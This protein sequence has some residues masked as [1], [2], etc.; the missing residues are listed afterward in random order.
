VGGGAVGIEYAGEVR[1]FYPDK[2]ATIV[3][4]EPLLLSKYFPDKF[5]KRMQEDVRAADADIILNDYLEDLDGEE[6]T[7][8]TTRAGKT[9]EA[10]LVVKAFGGKPATQF[11]KSLGDDVL[12]PNGRIRVTKTLQLIAHPTIFAAGDATDWDESKQ[13]VPAN[14]Q[15]AVVVSNILALLNGK[16]ATKIYKPPPT[17]ILV[18]NGRSRGVTYIGLLW[19]LVFGNWFSSFVKNYLFKTTKKQFG[20]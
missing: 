9:V 13:V 1:D 17:S 12:A 4:G 6:K 2:R 20:Y 15:A 19:G 16:E 8:Y 10:D 5:R 7:V 3:H 14:F 18:S 11:V